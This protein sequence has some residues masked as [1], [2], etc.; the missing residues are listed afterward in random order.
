MNQFVYNTR[1]FFPII[2][3]DCR[4]M[5]SSHEWKEGDRNNILNMF[6][7]QSDRKIT[8]NQKRKHYEI[9]H[10]QKVIYSMCLLLCL[11]IKAMF[12]KT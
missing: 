11:Q 1:T 4:V 10:L 7:D 9:N 6:L 2:L 12:R 8:R 3:I 5:I